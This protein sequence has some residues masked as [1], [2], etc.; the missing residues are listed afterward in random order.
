MPQP[1]LIS[2]VAGN[3][4]SRA[5]QGPLLGEQ[6]VSMAEAFTRIKMAE[7]QQAQQKFATM[8]QNIQTLPTS[9][10][11]LRKAAKKAGMPLP[12]DEEIAA[13][14]QVGQQQKATTG[15]TGSARPVTPGAARLE[16][17]QGGGTAGAAGASPDAA[18]AAAQ[19]KWQDGMTPE[20]GL[21]FVLNT[22]YNRGQ[23]LAAAEFKQKMADTEAKAKGSEFESRMLDVKNEIMTDPTKG[24]EGMGKMMAVGGVP[25]NITQLALANAS[26]EQKRNVYRMSLGYDVGEMFK[27]LVTQGGMSVDKA[28]TLANNMSPGAPL[29]P[30]QQRM[31]QTV[32]FKQLGE[33]ATVMQQLYEITGD[34][35]AA[36]I[37]AMKVG[38]GMPLADALPRK[39]APIVQKEMDLRKRQ[40][41]AEEARVGVERKKASYEERRVAA[42]EKS[43]DIREKEAKWK[44]EANIAKLHLMEVTG[45][46]TELLKAYQLYISQKKSGI[47][48]DA[49]EFQKILDQLQA[50]GITDPQDLTNYLSGQPGAAVPTGD[51]LQDE[52]GAPVTAAKPSAAVPKKTP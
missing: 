13:I 4:E 35:D 26:P 20:K 50:V 29:T 52:L 48:P 25:F 36:R 32:N 46:N 42:Y 38:A 44:R 22:W 30:E 2:G 28:W 17:T 10:T 14:A 43:I 21:Q 9:A 19:K 24:A 7:K 1:S 31:A 37:T 5:Y 3:I 39:M 15:E 6:L 12:S 16:G 41:G 18:A 27:T 49:K 40:I 51:P 11:E 47:E 33:Q 8:M 23:Q 34:A 45:E